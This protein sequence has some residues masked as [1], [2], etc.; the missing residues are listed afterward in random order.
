[1]NNVLTLRKRKDMTQDEFAEY[2]GISRI[3]IARYEAGAEVSRANAERIAKAC[4]VSVAYVLREGDDASDDADAWELR[5]RLR[6]D[7]DMRILF[8]AASK[9]SPEHIRIAA[10][11]LKQLEPE[12]DE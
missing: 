2:C 11:L 1:M 3:S 4:H 7:P 6:R 10:N 5:E 9:A 8:D 12:A